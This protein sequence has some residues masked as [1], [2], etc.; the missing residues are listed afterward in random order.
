MKSWNGQVVI[1]SCCAVW[2]AVAAYAQG[3]RG[4]NDWGTVG[5]D[6]QRSGW[7]RTDPKI[8]PASMQKPGFAFLWKQKV[9]SDTKQLNSLTEAVLMDRYIGYRGFRS[10]AHF[11]TSGDKV[12]AFDSDLGRVEWQ[13]SIG[14]PSAQPGTLAC[15][16]GLTASLARTVGVSV[17]V[18]GQVGRGGG[19]GRGGPAKSGVGEAGQGAVTLAALN[20][21]Q[22]GGGNR[23]G[24][25]G[26]PGA[27]GAPAAR[28]GGGGQQRM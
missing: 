2:C 23:G 15:P 6:A 5:N 8:S 17:P 13:K 24:F 4:G 27:P 26:A 11:A 3:G 1:S 25:P 12:I 20:Q 18:A 14:T 28:G 9:A 22:M 21:Q 10:Y 16:G 19:G 7:V